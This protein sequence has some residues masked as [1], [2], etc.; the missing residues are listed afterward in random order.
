MLPPV[1][2]GS[3]PA[4]AVRPADDRRGSERRLPRRAAWIDVAAVDPDR[5]RARET[6]LG[7][8]LVRPNLAQ[9]DGRLDPV[10]GEHGVQQLERLGM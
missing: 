7:R 5:R 9:L 3:G 6:E 1:A 10:L 4:R 2:R 8:L